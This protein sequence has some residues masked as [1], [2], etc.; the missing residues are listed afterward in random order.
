[1]S[2]KMASLCCLYFINNIN[3]ISSGN[4][5]LAFQDALESLLANGVDICGLSETNL[6]WLRHAVRNQC[7]KICNDFYGTSLL[8][9]LTSSL[10]TNNTYKPGGTCT[11]LTQ[12]YCGWHGSSGSDPHGLGHWS[13]IRLNGKNNKSLVIVMAYISCV[14][15]IDWQGGKLNGIPP[16][17]ASRLSL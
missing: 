7:G 3:G 13:F 14:Q 10:R 5:F 8:S 16:R 4:K 2:K 11:G 9:T 12:Q 15:S 1:M 6:D 17:M